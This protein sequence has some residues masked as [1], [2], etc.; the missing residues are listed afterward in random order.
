MFAQYPFRFSPAEHGRRK[1]RNIGPLA[2]GPPASR[3]KFRVQQIIVLM[4]HKKTAARL[5]D[6]KIH[7]LQRADIFRLPGKP[8]PRVFDAC[9]DRG[10]IVRRSIVRNDQFQVGMSLP[11]CR[12]N[13][14]SQKRRPVMRGDANGE[15]GLLA[16]PRPVISPGRIVE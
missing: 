6:Q 7:V 14:L 4:E 10:R 13:R 11:Q 1:E 16:H 2:Q 3:K 12:V 9:D 15:E 8:Q 5:V